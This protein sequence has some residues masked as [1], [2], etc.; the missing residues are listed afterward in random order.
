MNK[1]VII[2]GIGLAAA[3][4]F[5]A[6]TKNEV[7]SI[8][9]APQKISFSPLTGKLST[10]A[11]LDGSTYKSTDPSFG[12]FGYYLPEG[13]TWDQNYST[14]SLYVPESE[15]KN[16][17]NSDTGNAWTTET[18]YYWPKTGG[19]TFFAYSPYNYQEAAGGKL[20]VNRLNDGMYIGNPLGDLSDLYDVDAHQETDILVADVQ[21]DCSGSSTNGGYSGVPIVFR[22]KLSQIVGI[23]FSTVNAN[24]EP[25]D[26]ANGHDGS[27]GKEYEAGDVVFQLLKVELNDLSVKGAYI[28]HMGSAEK[29]EWMASSA[30][31]AK[32]DYIWYDKSSGNATPDQFGKAALNLTFNNYYPNAN[33]YLLILPQDLEKTASTQSTEPYFQISY[34]VLTYTDAV[35]HSTEVVNKKVMLHELHASTLIEKNKRIRYTFRITLD[36]QQIYW[37]PSI[38]NWEG[39][40]RNMQF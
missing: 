4:M 10:K 34:Q 26:Y 11:L 1:T 38:E 21:K 19:I 7:S 24:G 29:D 27:N 39:E 12:V 3:A 15:V 8:A 25:K 30:D 9:D 36:N 5:S 37:A 20:P 22:H 31:E 14:A 18:A 35:N 32:K 6:C 40:S 33:S 28:L 2:S 23:D 17:T 13:K 16:S